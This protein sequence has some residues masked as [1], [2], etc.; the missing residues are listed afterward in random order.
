MDEWTEWT[1][2]AFKIYLEKLGRSENTVNSY[3][4]SVRFF[5]S[6]YR[7]L[8]IENLK[9]YRDFLLKKYELNTV[10]TRIYGMNRY[11]EFLYKSGSLPESMMAVAESD[12]APDGGLLADSQT[13][14]TPP[15]DTD[16]LSGDV[17]TREPFYLPPVKAPGSKNI[18][19]MQPVKEQKKTYLDTVISQ[20]DYERLKRCL[21]RD[22]NLYWY[23]VV[24]FLGATG[25]RISELLQIKIEDLKLGYLDLYSK[26]GKIRRLYFP[27]SLCGE[28]IPWFMEHGI[29]SGF[30]FLNH[31]G[32]LITSRG[33]SLQLKHLAVRYHINPDTVYP[34]SF[35]HRFAKNFLKRFNDISLLADLMGHDSIETTRIYL[36]RSSQEQKALLDRIITW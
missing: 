12:S 23:F 2:N 9:N 31:R 3:Y 6:L 20:R 17:E 1:L 18:Y 27:R 16:A 36:T 19:R 11:L 32:K 5:F 14:L 26:G 28:A 34:H 4:R 10:N 29:T 7:E 30:I 8:S 25:A 22:G 15:V 35:R 33:I 24:R 13:A 21:K